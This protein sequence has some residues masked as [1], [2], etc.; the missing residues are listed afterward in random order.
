VA[1]KGGRDV[2]TVK[3]T[4]A[5]KYCTSVPEGE[6]ERVNPSIH[7]RERRERKIERARKGGGRE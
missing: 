6:D 4:S 2:A 5:P 1:R 3:V 7:G